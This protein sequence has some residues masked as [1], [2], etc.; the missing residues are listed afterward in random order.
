MEKKYRIPYDNYV[1]YKGIRLFQIEALKSFYSGSRLIEKGQRGGYIEAQACLPQYDNSWIDNGAFALNGAL[2]CDNAYVG[3]TCIID[4]ATVCGDAVVTENVVLQ[5]GIRV[6]GA[7]LSGT[8]KLSGNLVIHKNI[9]F[10]KK[11]ID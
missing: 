3:D 10:D 6:D 9:I 7:W 8:F 5:D 2:I 11:E 4:G 1:D